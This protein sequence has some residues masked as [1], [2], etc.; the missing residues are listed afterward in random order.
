MDFARDGI[1]SAVGEGERVRAVASSAISCAM[2]SMAES[3]FCFLLR[4]MVGTGCG[5]WR[6]TLATGRA[7]M[8]PE[9][10]KRDEV[11]TTKGETP[12]IFGARFGGD[13]LGDTIAS[14]GLGLGSGGGCCS[15]TARGGGGGGTRS[16][17]LTYWNAADSVDGCGTGSLRSPTGTSPSFFLE[18]SS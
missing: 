9:P 12:R 10:A 8:F 13:V 3:D 7:L 18:D 4:A 2:D 6:E 1:R 17:W 15:F 14:V 16:C 11:V 5:A